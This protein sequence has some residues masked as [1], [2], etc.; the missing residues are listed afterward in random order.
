MCG[1]VL[2][3]QQ[4]IGEN[5]QLGTISTSATVVGY[6]VVR[7]TETETVQERGHTKTREFRRRNGP[8]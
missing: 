5:K 8:F 3:Y 4:D 1:L 6:G 2:Q 7:Q